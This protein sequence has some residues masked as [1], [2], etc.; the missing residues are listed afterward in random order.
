MPRKD[1]AAK[2]PKRTGL[3]SV[4]RSGARVSGGSENP[5][6]TARFIRDLRTTLLEILENRPVCRGKWS[7]KQ[8]KPEERLNPNRFNSRSQERRSGRGGG[9]FASAVQALPVEP[10]EVPHSEGGK[11]ALE[12]V[13]LEKRKRLGPVA[14]WAEVWEFPAQKA[15]AEGVGIG[16]FK[17]LKTLK[18]VKVSVVNLFLATSS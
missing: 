18:R 14:F 10:V 7:S 4:K 13:E 6:R 1:S 11:E 12:H 8:C 2:P 3:D 17:F 9:V 5:L 15:L 16:G